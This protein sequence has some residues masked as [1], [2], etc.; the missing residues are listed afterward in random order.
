M[1]RALGDPDPADGDDDT[2]RTLGELDEGEGRA[3]PMLP[4]LLGPGCDD[5]GRTLAGGRTLGTF[6]VG[7]GGSGA[8]LPVMR[9]NA[10]SAN[11]STS[12]SMAR[13]LG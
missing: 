1:G 10:D 11:A 8:T 5:W 3:L 12:A 6:C 4:L 13:M 7:G 9:P 2:G